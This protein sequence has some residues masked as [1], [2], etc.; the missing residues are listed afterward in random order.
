MNAHRF[1]LSAFLGLAGFAFLSPAPLAAQDQDQP[2]VDNARHNFIG[3]V[4]ANA[5]YVRSGPGEGFYPTQK[6]DRGA[7]LT[8]VGMRFEWLKITPPEG[9]FCY[10]AKA[11]VEKR[12]DGTVGR[13]TRPNLNV[14]AGSTLNAMKTTVQTKLNEGDDVRIIGE[15][16]EYFMIEPPEGAYLYVHQQFVEPVRQIEPAMAERPA[17]RDAAQHAD[18]IASAPVPTEGRPPEDDS[19]QAEVRRDMTDDPESPAA[20]ETS[21]RPRAGATAGA[22]PAVSPE[23]EFDR[24]EAE[25]NQVSQQPIEEQPVDTLI[26]GYQKVVSSPRLPESMR[27]IAEHRLA[28]LKVRAEAREHLAEVQRIR[29]EAEQRR[30]AL[31]A[32]KEELEERIRDSEITAYTAV[33]MLHTSSLQQGEGTLYRLTDPA[34]GRTVIYLRTDDA[35]YAGRIG[36]FVGVRGE[37]TREPILNARVIRPTE[38]E[39][40]NQNEVNRSITAQVAPASLLPRRPQASTME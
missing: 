8:V 39:P 25:F 14:R 36:Q 10:V 5:V 21:D 12:G 15:R 32:E 20:T 29:Q 16:D 2:E 23:V 1:F 7:Q 3:R 11:Y 6:L 30:L 40:V 33:G 26:E 38:L 19:E 37:I 35:K 22:A 9:S 24:L 31:Q 13:V 27:R 18:P 17:I 28:V 34:N 4:N